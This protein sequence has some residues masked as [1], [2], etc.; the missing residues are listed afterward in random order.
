MNNCK[1]LLFIL[2]NKKENIGTKYSE[3]EVSSSKI[4]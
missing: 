4:T 1:V 3:K 2:I